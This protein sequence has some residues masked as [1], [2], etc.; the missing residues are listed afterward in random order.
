[1][2]WIR[3]AAVAV[4]GAA[5][6]LALAIPQVAGLA[7][8]PVAIGVLVTQS[9]PG[10]VIQGTQVLDGLNIAAAMINHRGGVLGRPLKLVVEDTSGLP[11][12]GRSGAEKL[13]TRD[14]VV[15]ITGE[16][17]SSVCLA[18]IEV[19]HRYGVPYVNTNCWADAVREKGYPEVFN[20]SP[21]N[22]LVSEA[23]ARVIK[24]MGVRRIVAF[25]ENTDYGIG[26][27]KVLEQKL[28][29]L[30]PGTAFTYQV[31]DRTASD[32][33]PTI[34]PLRT[35]PPDM[36]VTILL[37]PAGY[38]LMNQLY[39]QGIAPAPRTWLFD[40]SGI[41]DYPD[42]WDN[43]KAAGKYLIS[44]GFYHPRMKLTPFGVQVRDA[45]VRQTKHEPGRLIF[46]AADSLLVLADAL[47]RAGS[48]DH[49]A[50]IR[51][52]S[53]T[54]VLGT[55]GTITFTKGHGATFQQWTGIP[56]V[57]YQ[58]TD[59]R[60]ALEETRLIAGPGVA[61]DVHRLLKP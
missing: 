8:E 36:V 43:V 35:N 54:R 24:D 32:F 15:A 21:W 29:E 31:V 40:G 30:S 6:A 60:Q 57:V 56:Y 19:V 5:V 49:A 48:T 61:L 23:M 58:F 14:H 9:P 28:K 26:Q 11:E 12:K 3:R 39:E 7:E 1:M 18:E 33:T 10:S 52:L 13:I 4:L 53:T 45:Y 37:P 55:R 22:S 59:V 27:A 20:T 16:H 51:A 50:V 42:F 46:Q 44:L 41:S 47:R 34:L 17:Q 25:A 38:L 2:T